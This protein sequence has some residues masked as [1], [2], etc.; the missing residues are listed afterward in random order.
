MRAIC[1]Y[2]AHIVS[3]LTQ[4]AMHSGLAQTLVSVLLYTSYVG[5]I[6]L[7]MFRR[8]FFDTSPHDY[9]YVNIMRLLYV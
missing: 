6:K 5:V 8:E 4:D 7:Y 1:P 9:S 3:C 2:I